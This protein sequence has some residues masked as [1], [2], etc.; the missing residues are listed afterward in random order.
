MNPNACLTT[1]EIENR[2]R[3]A[4]INATAQRIAICRY[5]LCDADHPTV[6]DIKSWADEN[7]PKMSLATVYNTVHTLEEAGLLRSFQFP[8][9]DKVVYDNTL[10]DHYHLCDADTGKVVD[11]PLEAVQ[12]RPEL[13]EGYDVSSAAI[14]FYGKKQGTDN[15]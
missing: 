10:D 3:E 15:P 8:H 12:L 11:V 14:V 6:E 9:C 5:V 7:F 13:I 1:A 2:L 4:G